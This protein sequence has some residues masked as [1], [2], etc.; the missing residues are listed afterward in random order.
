MNSLKLVD[1]EEIVYVN[2]IAA[3]PLLSVSLVVV[4]SH[5]LNAWWWW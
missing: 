2:V 4:F 1:I 3:G 5:H